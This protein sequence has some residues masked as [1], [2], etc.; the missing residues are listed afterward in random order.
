[1]EV[2]RF[3]GASVGDGVEKQVTTRDE[4]VRHAPDKQTR[5]RLLLSCP[6]I[7]FLFLAH[8]KDSALRMFIKRASEPCFLSSSNCKT[9]R[10]RESADAARPRCHRRYLHLLAQHA[11][12]NVSPDARP[13]AHTHKHTHT[14]THANN[15]STP[16]HSSNIPASPT[17][18]TATPPFLPNKQKSHP[19]SHKHAIKQH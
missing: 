9:Q 16:K 6:P 15:M 11:R 3:D 18:P 12:Q 10:A 5:T 7:A 13:P 17:L 2:K 4:R 19:L 1:M 8:V 14:R